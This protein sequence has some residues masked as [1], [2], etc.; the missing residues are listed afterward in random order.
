MV[1]DTDDELA[2]YWPSMWP[3]EDGGPTRRQAPHGAA[4]PTIRPGDRL[5]VT[6]RPVLA[7]T[8]VVHRDPGELYLL[9]HSAGEGATCW[10]ERI[11]AV[12]LATVERSPDLPGGPVWPGGI[13][14]HRNGDLYVTFGNH[15]HRLAPDCAPVASAVL[16]RRLPYNSFVVL[17]D[18]VLVTKDFAKDSG[19]SELLALEPDGLETVARLQLPERSMA[20]LSAA[21]RTVYV[22]GDRSLLRV[23]W[24]GVELVA[25]DGFAA[26][27]RRL[28]GQTYG[29]DAVIAGGAAWFLDDGEGT[30]AYGGTFRGKGVSP[31]P[32]HLVRVDLATGDVTLAE[33]CGMP[34]G[35]IANPPAVDFQRGIAV[36][37][38]SSNGALTGFTIDA[39]DRGAHLERAWS[40]RQDHA[41]HMLHYPGTGELVT[42]D[43][44]DGRGGEQV[45]VLDIASGEEL[46]R[47]PTGSPV[48]GVLFPAPGLDRDFYSVTF[49]TVSRFVVRP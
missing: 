19:P 30:E 16:P 10:V 20:R 25:D 46:A 40:R 4:A 18:G 8:M 31:A 38:D 37:Y 41:A 35:L 15:V 21:G 17:P 43:H 34:N 28:D 44:D 9:A 49:T 12:S 27:Y 5:E 2:G 11:D 47:A 23:V 14:V 45:V 39:T 26:P 24:D 36:G 1:A 22:V 33:V 13:A 29:W 48:Q 6:H 32:L 42:F 7:G 3:A